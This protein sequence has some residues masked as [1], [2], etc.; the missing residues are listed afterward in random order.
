MVYP[1]PTSDRLF[2]QVEN[3]EQLKSVIVYNLI[4]EKIFEMSDLNSTNC[5]ITFNNFPKGI[6]IIQIQGEK[7][8]NVKK[9]MHK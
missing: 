7:N 8:L 4:G 9:I 1:N 2:I 3:E 6:Y 5:S